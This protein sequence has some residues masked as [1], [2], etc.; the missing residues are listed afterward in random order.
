VVYGFTLGALDLR[1]PR[2]SLI[3]GVS[4]FV[5]QPA[6]DLLFQE[7]IRFYVIIH[8]P[9]EISATEISPR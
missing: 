4:F 8:R 2:L 6:G 7:K 3:L 1:H 5:V 9:D